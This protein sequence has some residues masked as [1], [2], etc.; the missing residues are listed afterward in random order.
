MEESK[1]LGP[2]VKGLFTTVKAQAKQYTDAFERL[3]YELASFESIKTEL[4]KVP[5]QIRDEVNN[6]I[7]E[8]KKNFEDTIE[9]LEVKFER[10]SNIY[11]DFENIRN[12]RDELTIMSTTLIKLTTEINITLNNFK[13]HSQTVLDSLVKESRQ[14]IDDEMEKHA[15]KTESK[16][17][18]KIRK[19]EGK[20]LAF[21]Q[22]LWSVSNSQNYDIKRFASDI[23]SMKADIPD[24]Q[25]AL[26]TF[27]NIIK[28]SAS[29]VIKEHAK[30]IINDLLT[31]EKKE[32]NDQL[33]KIERFFSQIN[34]NMPTS[35]AFSKSE[36]AH[37][38]DFVLDMKTI[39]DKSNSN[40]QII[41]SM[42]KKIFTLNSQLEVLHKSNVLSIVIGILSLSGILIIAYILLS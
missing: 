10:I 4:V 18:I 33:S 32:I 12:L 26:A 36:S 39:N 40:E 22:K 21:D 35:E 15:S 14:R 13:S 30:V 16:L 25:D 23:K 38:D 37:F 27:D 2:E 3:S 5:D 31:I 1:A 17:T 24:L 9:L 6:T 8:L 41:N 11:N 34:I 42:K 19:L 28:R 29:G 20:L 7:Q